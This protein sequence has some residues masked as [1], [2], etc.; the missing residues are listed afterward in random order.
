MLLGNLESVYC[1]SRACSLS[2]DANTWRS[3]TLVLNPSALGVGVIAPS[4]A[5]ASTSNSPRCWTLRTI[6]GMLLDQTALENGVSHEVRFAVTLEPREARVY[7]L[8]AG[9]AC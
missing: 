6:D 8:V 4:T 1:A 9:G 2:G 7:E 5:C 3:V